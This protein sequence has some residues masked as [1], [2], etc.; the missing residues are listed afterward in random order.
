MVESMKWR[1]ISENIEEMKYFI[2]SQRGNENTH[3]DKMEYKRNQFNANI[4]NCTQIIV[5]LRLTF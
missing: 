5:T 3:Y 2:S 4:L 1:S